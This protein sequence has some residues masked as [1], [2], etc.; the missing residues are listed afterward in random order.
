MN[1]KYPSDKITLFGENGKKLSEEERE[2]QEKALREY[3]QEMMRPVIT[4]IEKRKKGA[5]SA[6][7][8]LNGKNRQT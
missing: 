8:D 2:R 7:R 6:K 4:D 1:F 5:A 3:V